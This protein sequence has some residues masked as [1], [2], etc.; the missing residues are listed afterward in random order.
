MD[1]RQGMGKK[2]CALALQAVWL[3]LAPVLARATPPRLLTPADIQAIANDST[4]WNALKTRCDN[5][6]NVIVQGAY[7]GFDNSYS[8]GAWRDAS[9]DYGTCYNVAKFKGDTVNAD[10]YSKKAVA[11]MKAMARDHW[12]LLLD[13]SGNPIVKPAH[14]FVAIA[15]GV[16]TQFP[17]RMAP[18]GPVSVY[19]SPTSEISQTYR[20]E[21]TNMAYT[22][23][24]NI[25][26]LPGTLPVVKVSNT[27]GG[28]ADY[29]RG[30]DYFDGYYHMR[31]SAAKHP[32]LNAVYYLTLANAQT[33]TAAAGA[34]A[35]GNTLTFN[36]PPPAGQA[37]FVVYMGPNYE[38][39]GNRKGS[40]VEGTR[41]DAG[42]FMRNITVGLAIAYD[43]MR[44]SPDMTPALRQEFYTTLNAHV[45][46][47]TYGK[48][49]AG[50]PEYD[51][52]VFTVLGNYTTRG[53]Q[54]AAMFT[55]YGT[56]DD[57]PRAMDACVGSNCLKPFARSLLV[58]TADALTLH[59]PG[60]FGYEGQYANGST[61]DWLSVFDTYKT[62]TAAAGA[63]EDLT[64]AGWLQNV[65]PATIHGTKPD[66]LTF[67]DGGDW[68]TLPAQP[69]ATAMKAFAQFRANHAMAPYARQLLSDVGQSVAGA[70]TDY[71]SG[72]GAFPLSF[73]ARGTGVLYAR[74]SWTDPAAVWLSMAAGPVFD[75]NHGHYDRGHFT[76]QRGADYLV[77]DAGRYG[78]RQTHPFHN[79]LAF[80][81]YMIQEIEN[82]AAAKPTKHTEGDGFVYGQEDM[83]RSYRSEIKRAVRT[84]VYIR[85]DVVLVHDQAQTG[86]AGTPKTFNVNFHAPS[87]AHA[88]GS[89]LFSAVRGASKVFM[90]SLVP[91]NPD[92][93]KTITAA[94]YNGGTGNVTN[95]KV[96]TTGTANDTFLHV[97]QMT[98][99]GQ[100]AMAA[101]S[102]VQSSDGRTQGASVDMGAR[103]W[104]V[105]SA[106]TAAVVSGGTLSYGVPQAC[107]CTHVLG[108]LPVNTT[109]QIAVQGPGGTVSAATDGNGVL[110]FSTDNPATSGVQVLLSGGVADTLAPARPRNL[111]IR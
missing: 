105:L 108:D 14:E 25:V 19:L 92:P 31:W 90:R 99:S 2:A 73:L 17:L 45:D 6:L 50:S 81:N 89:D 69:L 63:P 32:A 35:S 41:T 66:R 15:D 101:S 93:L 87:V 54:P 5:N 51:P 91:A 83:T 16:T 65:V 82:G 106:S 38:Q 68:N 57:N 75:V 71:K 107:P 20:N 96:T 86:N 74:S 43:L 84:L 9:K 56:D 72:P 60:G 47:V 24:D 11:L 58:K 88:S 53:Y 77:L 29:A 78:A 18:A 22:G 59:L 3:V 109:Y 4:A 39:T 98:P 7:G 1:K 49:T 55:A 46:W 79:T 62:V 26:S 21:T 30:T 40:N 8:A 61:N 48:L 42:Y 13:G 103:R 23:A 95:Y 10:R 94:D 80:N 110:T 67:Y 33:M 36:T 111:R 76:F 104:L 70:Q 85:P 100:A 34:S 12:Y 64:P 37:I 28:P 102:Y 97:F 44:E 52:Y 27:S